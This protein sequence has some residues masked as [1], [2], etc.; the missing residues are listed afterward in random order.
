MS[1]LEKFT[2]TLYGLFL[3]DQDTTTGHFRSGYVYQSITMAIVPRSNTRALTAVGSYARL[4]GVGF[5]E[6][7]VQ[8]GDVVGDKFG[9]YWT[10]EGKKLWSWGDKFVVYECDLSQKLNFPF[11]SGFFGFEILS[12]DEDGNITQGFETGFERGYFAL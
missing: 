9:R 3:G 12:S 1:L 11:T 5:T 4:D 7:E 10:I 8:I 6:Y 2:V